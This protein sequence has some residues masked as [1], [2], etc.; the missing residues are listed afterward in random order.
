[1]YIVEQEFNSRL[2]QSPPSQGSFQE[3]TS[4]SPPFSHPNVT[5]TEEGYSS[6][7]RILTEKGIGA[8]VHCG[9]TESKD[10]MDQHQPFTHT[11]TPLT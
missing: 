2:A 6:R 8:P 10:H 11:A 3:A 4:P 7:N 1:M 5:V 9:V